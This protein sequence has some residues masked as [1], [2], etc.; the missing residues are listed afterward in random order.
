M[1]HWVWHTH[2]IIEIL[3]LVSKVDQAKWKTINGTS[4]PHSLPWQEFT[5]P[6]LKATVCS[7]VISMISII[8]AVN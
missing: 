2:G 1:L 6:S 7:P 3:N 8:I 4:L 5:G